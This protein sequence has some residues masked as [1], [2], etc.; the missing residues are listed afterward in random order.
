[1][2]NSGVWYNSGLA[3]LSIS[4]VFKQR[5]RQGFYDDILFTESAALNDYILDYQPLH[6]NPWHLHE[7]HHRV[8]REI[9][10]YLQWNFRAYGRTFNLQ[11]QPAKSIFTDSHELV[12]GNNPPA[13]V[14][15]SFIY[16]G[17]LAGVPS[18]SAYLSIING[19]VSGHVI[20][21]ADTTYHIEPARNHFKSSEFHTLI[22]QESQMNLDPYRHKRNTSETCGGKEIYNKL[23]NM[24]RPV[25]LSE[26]RSKQKWHE[27]THNKYSSEANTGEP[28][29]RK[30]RDFQNNARTC[31]M[32]LQADYLL[33]KHF[34][35]KTNNNESAKEEIL[36]LFASHIKALNDIY[37][38]TKFVRSDNPDVF[39]QHTNFQL[40]RTKIMDTCKNDGFCKDNLDVS[41]FLDL[42]AEEN[43]DQFCLVHTFTYRDFVGG[44]LGLAWVATAQSPN[45]G[46]C[47][48][49][50]DVRDSNNGI[51]RRSLNTGIVT[52]INFKQ[53]VP[54]RVSQLTF[55]HEVGHNFGSQ[56]DTTEKCA[57]YGTGEPNASDGNYIMFPS[58]TQGNL[59][60]NR[61]FS[62]CSKD[63]IARVLETLAPAGRRPSCFVE[64]DQPFCGNKIV[65]EGEECDCGMVEE[66][67]DSCCIARNDSNAGTSCKRPL[68][69]KC[70]PSEG[71]CCSAQCEF[72]SNK[73]C[74]QP[75]DCSEASS[76]NLTF[77]SRHSKVCL[78]GECI[79]SVCQRINWTECFLT[80][81]EVTGVEQMCYVSCSKK[82][83][84]FQVLSF[85]NNLLVCVCSPCNNYKGYCDVFSGSPCNNYKGYCDVFSKCRNVDAEG[86]FRQLTDLIF[87]EET[88]N[89]IK[90]WIEDHWWAVLLMCIGV[91][92]FMG[93]FVKIFEYNTPS[94]DPK[95][96]HQTTPAARS[97]PVP[98][99]QPDKRAGP[100]TTNVPMQ[101]RQE[102]GGNQGYNN[103]AFQ[104]SAFDQDYDS[105]AV[106]RPTSS[107]GQQQF[108]RVS[109]ARQY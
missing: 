58:A 93:V 11:L 59:P 98:R 85:Q 50:G 48:K 49:Y 17:N 69:V 27:T 22:Y 4:L 82:T 100:Y 108:D 1:M 24:W 8:T 64:S 86:P 75:S 97:Q 91:I 39:F 106:Q 3:C 56:H 13:R 92:V 88:W 102:H 42:T 20:V 72:E 53:E 28:L 15:T 23:K 74:L 76:S 43:F 52:L 63:A 109:K 57:P 25:K 47:G 9:D 44:T 66:C 101:N 31:T 80:S 38:Q 6:F 96:K 95:R 65:E 36:A 90:T 5:L 40:Q 70:S 21:P 33:Y 35:E 26:D 46:I 37:G 107:R 51:A 78:S 73:Q 77:C 89:T 81:S 41:N 94:K 32:S 34:L 12:I 30:K 79:G 99:S 104:G 71:P 29:S 14:D 18:S 87:K 7:K 83:F 84:Y 67:K 68:N 54:P 10:P 55:A 103:Y 16:E 19:S 105:G 61:Q 62:T 45:A 2:L 60:N